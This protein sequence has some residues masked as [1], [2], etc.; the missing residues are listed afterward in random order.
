MRLKSDGH[1]VEPTDTSCVITN[2]GYLEPYLTLASLAW[3]ELIQADNKSMEW[4]DQ[5]VAFNGFNIQVRAK[6]S[7]FE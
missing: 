4:I 5:E 7:V 6:S 3:N 1:N 2:P